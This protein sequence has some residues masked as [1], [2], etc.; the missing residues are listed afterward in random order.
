[1]NHDYETDGLIERSRKIEKSENCFWI[2]AGTIR[3]R[4]RE[5]RK[6]CLKLV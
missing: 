3:I 5:R 6:K 1:M 2:E 4:L